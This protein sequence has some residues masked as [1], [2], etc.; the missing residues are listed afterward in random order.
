[1]ALGNAPGRGTITVTAGQGTVPNQTITVSNEGDSTV[2][3]TA[4]R[5]DPGK[6]R[7][8]ARRLRQPASG[9][10]HVLGLHADLRVK[11]RKCQMFGRANLDLL[12][13]QDLRLSA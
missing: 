9:D 7:R 1:M 4:R 10:Q 3:G 13:K 8:R 2:S 12:R 11:A 6:R 5:N